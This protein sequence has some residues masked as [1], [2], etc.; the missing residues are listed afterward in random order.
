MIFITQR[1]TFFRQLI[2]NQQ[3]GSQKREW[4]SKF[5]YWNQPSSCL[6]VLYCLAFLGR[7]QLFQRRYDFLAQSN[8]SADSVDDLSA[9]EKISL[10]IIGI[11]SINPNISVPSDI[12]AHN[13]F[14]LSEHLKSQDYLNIN[15]IKKWT[16]DQKMVRNEK[17]TKVM[18]FNFTDIYTFTA[19]LSLD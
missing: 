14:I 15:N 3:G 16:D 12:P 19:K 2:I 5:S 7:R 10:I 6:F 1:A 9:L 8:H 13:Q 4:W 18:I 11:A 17:K